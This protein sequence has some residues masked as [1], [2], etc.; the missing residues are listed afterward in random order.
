MSEHRQPGDEA[1]ILAVLQG[2]AAALRPKDVLRFVASFHTMPGMIRRIMYALALLTPLVIVGATA[3]PALATTE[4]DMAN[5]IVSTLLNN[6]FNGS[7]FNGY[8]DCPTTNTGNSGQCWWWAAVTW[9]ALITYGENNPSSVYTRLIEDD[10]SKTY[11]TICNSYTQYGPW[12]KC[13]G[14]YDQNGLDPFTVNEAGNTYFD[15]IGWWTQTWID[16]YQLTGALE[17]KYLAEELWNY[18]TNNGFKQTTPK[19]NPDSSITN[20]TGSDYGVVQYH[21]AGG[22]V[23]VPDIFANALYLRN[24]AKLYSSTS[25]AYFRNQY[26]L[27]NSNGFGG[28]N[29]AASYIR[30]HLIFIYGGTLGNSD[31]K[32]MMADHYSYTNGACESG[33]VQWQLHGQGEMVQA[34][35][36]LATACTSNSLCANGPGWYNNLADELANSV[37]SDHSGSVFDSP[38]SGGPP[39]QN[40]PTVDNY[41]IL[42]EPCIPDSGNNWPE[43]CNVG[44][45][46]QSYPAWLI[47]KGVFEHAIYCLNG[48][49]S[50]SDQTLKDFSHT[51]GSKIL[52]ANYGFLWDPNNYNDSNTVVVFATRTSDLNGLEAD[53]EVSTIRETNSYATC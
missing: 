48:N 19:C 8:Q 46:I 16:A 6:D 41:G 49:L 37:V 34:W 24:S 21:K 17:Y 32:F 39:P 28:A 9:D 53:M 7:L 50:T 2:R 22:A 36:S 31:A 29:N 4:A 13:P 43:Q 23:G 18:A 1:R 27:G 42:S 20:P 10:L 52:G 45:D 3:Q 44:S 25:G 15:D 47:S 51:N 26:I 30:T 11:T 12:G 40:E 14:T 5:N 35:T 38:P 33:G